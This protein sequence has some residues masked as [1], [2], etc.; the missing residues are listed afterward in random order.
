MSQPWT[1]TAGAKAYA[2]VDEHYVEPFWVS[3]RLFEEETFR[4]RHLRSSLRL[5]P[6]RRVRDEGRH[7]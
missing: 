5:R 3:E 2:R 1:H 6:N 7:T 4:R